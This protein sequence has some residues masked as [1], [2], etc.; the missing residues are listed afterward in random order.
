MTHSIVL[1]DGVCVLRSRVVGFVIRH[2]SA[3]RFRF[4]SVQSWTRCASTPC[5]A[6]TRW[7]AG[8]LAR[9]PG[10]CCGPEGRCLTWS[11]LAASGGIGTLAYEAA[12]LLSDTG[13]DGPGVG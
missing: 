6:A 3:A 5:C 10:L 11:V 9:W 1:Y 8:P 2:D 13:D 4:A 12:G 7:P